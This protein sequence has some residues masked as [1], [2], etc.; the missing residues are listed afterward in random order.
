MKEALRAL[1]LSDPGVTALIDTRVSW[2]MLS[3]KSAL[4]ALVL[5]RISGGHDYVMQGTSPPFEARVQADCWGR[6]YADATALSRAVKAALSGYSGSE[7]NTVFQGVFLDAE[8]ELPDDA[9][10]AVDVLY[11]VC[12]DFRIWHKEE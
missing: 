9:T 3:R 8:H 1:L 10:E 11:R 7:G 4:P 6:T 2:G 12:L 5:T